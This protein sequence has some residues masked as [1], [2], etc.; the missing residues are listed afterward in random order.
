MKDQKIVEFMRFR[1]IFAMLSVLLIVISI[2]SLF[3]RGINFGLDFTGGT[4][5][6]LQYETT[7]D[8][9]SIRSRLSEEGY[10]G[11]VVIN[12][13]ADT[14]VLVRL[15]QTEPVNAQSATTDEANTEEDDASL[16]EV[17]LQMLQQDTDENIVLERVEVVGAQVGGELRDKGGIGMLFALIVVM[18]YVAVRFQYKFSVGAVAA[19]AHDVI[20]VLG[21]FSLLQLDF[22]LTVLAALLAVIGYSINDT[23]VVFDRIRENFRTIR[24]STPEEV[25]NISITQTLERTLMTSFTTLLVLLALFFIGGELIHN[26]SVALIVGIM[27]GTYSSIFISSSILLGMNISKEDLIP[28]EKEGADLKEIP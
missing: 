6:E 2:A 22:D 10:D 14:D 17:I 18:G 9:S 19:L 5:I 4:L 7:A 12:F 1:K 25:I 23:I 15:P 3:I 27:V 16:G 11:A 8:L 21:L 24:K 20:I 26:F 28:V 13:G